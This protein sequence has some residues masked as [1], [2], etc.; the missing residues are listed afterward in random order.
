MK[1]FYYILILISIVFYKNDIYALCSNTYTNHKSINYT[2]KITP[3]KSNFTHLNYADTSAKQGGVLQIANPYQFN[4]LNPFSIIGQTPANYT[5]AVFDSLFMAPLDDINTLQ[6]L[7]AKNYCLNNNTLKIIINNKAFWLNNKPITSIDIK[8]TLDYLK[9]INHPYY[10]HL[11]LSINNIK[12][13]NDLE[14]EINFININTNALIT[15]FT[16]PIVYHLDIKN[17]GINLLTKIPN[18]SGSY[19]V[20]TLAENRLIL[21]R[22]PNY[23]GANLGLKKYQFNFDSIVIS[24]FYN[25]KKQLIAFDNNQLS[26]YEIND[27][28]NLDTYKMQYNNK[29]VKIK[30]NNVPPLNALFLNTSKSYLN[31]IKIRKAIYLAYDATSLKKH[32]N[33]EALILNTNNNMEAKNLLEASKILDSTDYIFINNKRIHKI[34]KTQL[35]LNIVFNNKYEEQLSK[36]FLDNLKILGINVNSQILNGSQ[37]KDSIK[38]NNFDIMQSSYLYGKPIGEEIYY[39][40]FDYTKTKSIYNVNKLNNKTINDL[41]LS[42]LNTNDTKQREI[43]LQN[44]NEQLKSLYIFIPTYYYEDDFY[45][46]QS[47]LVYKQSDFGLDIWSSYFK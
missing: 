28:E 40:F 4:D 46:I 22:N 10:N 44:L 3:Y 8:A 38:N 15:L 18:S 5:M 30:K 34:S 27:L 43:K 21:N 36:H 16:L 39:Y 26:L 23:W 35:A 32:I 19:Y 7:I 13:I 25:N 24:Y 42:I 12:I 20:K 41:I 17:L 11:I 47:N 29:F 2:Q 37:I 14:I 31:D 45:L 33:K 9:Y 6:P 1:R